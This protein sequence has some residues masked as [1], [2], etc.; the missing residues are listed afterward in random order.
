MKKIFTILLALSALSIL[1]SGCKKA[2]E[3]TTDTTKPADTK[4][5]GE[6]AK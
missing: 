3:G 6:A 1:V 4:T 2:E 5:E